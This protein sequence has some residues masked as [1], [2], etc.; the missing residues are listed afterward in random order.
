MKSSIFRYGYN[1]N[2][3]LNMLLKVTIS[4]TVHQDFFCITDFQAHDDRSLAHWDMMN[5]KNEVLGHGVDD[6]I[7]KANKD[8]TDY[9]SFRRRSDLMGLPGG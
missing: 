4:T 5:T 6:A 9:R 8:E 2:L 3:F 1:S 7:Y